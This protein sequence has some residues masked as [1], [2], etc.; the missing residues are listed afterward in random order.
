MIDLIHNSVNASSARGTSLLGVTGG[1][2]MSKG[3]NRLQAA[4]TG[5]TATGDY[6]H[7]AVRMHVSP[8]FENFWA[9]CPKTKDHRFQHRKVAT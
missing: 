2:A 8:V 4:T 6:A 3:A 5:I 1:S 7:A 9:Y